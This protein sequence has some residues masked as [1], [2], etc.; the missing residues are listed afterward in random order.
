[1]SSTDAGIGTRAG[2]A[3]GSVWA[4]FTGAW[5]RDRWLTATLVWI[6]VAL[7]YVTLIPVGNNVILYPI[8]L[9]FAVIAG[10]NVVKRRIRPD[11]SLLL[12]A[13]LW[14]AFLA[15]GIIT[16]VVRDADS[17]GRTLVFFLLW[18]AVFSV[19]VLGFDRRVIRTV[20]ITGAWVSVFIGALLFVQ[21]LAAGDIL[22]FHRLPRWIEGPLHMAGSSSGGVV[23]LTATTIPPLLWWGGMWIASLFASAK[24]AYLPPVWLRTLAA[25]LIIIGAV[26]SWRRGVVIVLIATP[27]IA[28][29]ALLAL[30][31]RNRPKTDDV[32]FSW[33][34]L[35][36]IVIA[37]VIAA[38]GAFACQPHI[39]SMLG[40]VAHS[41]STVVSKDPTHLTT[42][43]LENPGSM[44][45]DETDTLADRI[46]TN[47]SQVLLSPHSPADWV[48]GRGF[49]ATIDRGDVQREIRPWQTELQYHAI[50]YWTGILGLLLVAATFVTAFLAVRKAFGVAGPLRGAL[51]VS[52]VGA[53]C[54]LAANASNPYLQAPGHMW[55]VFL[56]LMIAS[57]VFTARRQDAAATTSAPA[58]PTPAPAGNA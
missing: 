46:R 53:V 12:P 57:A 49:G 27:V 20:F 25:A 58:A 55:P 1:M 56:P 21:A 31:V 42:D 36:R 13:A 16:G 35:L 33:Q 51:Y 48:V 43:E 39:V 17:W 50:F 28:I 44:T 47:E 54:V 40:A 15:L 18:P 19:V 41:T 7:V 4:A 37:L 34:A 32:R 6:A 9:S 29:I 14:V 30:T 10:V 24:D 5:R 22:P 45:V 26:A 2:G 52:T 3:R 38:A 23:A 11:R 8:L